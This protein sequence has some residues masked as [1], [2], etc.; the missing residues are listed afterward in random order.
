[1]RITHWGHL[2]K[3]RRNYDFEHPEHKRVRS[4]ILWRI[5]DLGYSLDCFEEIDAW[6]NQ[7]NQ[8]Y[9]RSKNGGKT[10]R[11]GKKYSWIAYFEL[12]GLRGD[13]KLL[14]DYF[15]DVRISD[16]DIDPS[17]PVEPQEHNLVTKNLLGTRK[18]PN[19]E[20]VSKNLVPDLIP[21]LK[22]NQLC[23]EEGDW[24]LLQGNLRQEDNQ[25]RREILAFVQGQ[26]VKAEEYEEIIEGLKQKKIDAHPARFCPEDY[27]T[28]AGE[29]P[30]CDTFPTNC[31]EEVSCEL[32]VETVRVEQSN[33]QAFKI[34]AP[35]RENSWESYHS[36]IIAGRNIA[37]PSRQIAET[38]G[39][40]EQPQSFN[41]FEK[42]GR[43]ASMTFR[44]GHNLTESQTFTYL[45]EDLLKRYLED[46]DGELIWVIWGEQCLVSQDQDTSIKPFEELREFEEVIAYRH[47]SNYL[48]NEHQ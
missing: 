12:A 45:R 9:G 10:D 37:T 4:N 31:W 42:D 32:G 1:M 2:V 3:D 17:F 33:Y 40:C 48:Q 38:F 18:M 13:K 5:Y 20:W 19:K 8:I 35:V 28:Y 15:D 6:I 24:I 27:Y 39:L 46:I 14:P 11:Y 7:G 25:A 21:Y 23:G 47:L 30:W 22:V 43:C 41:L 26:I 34:L 16:A 36:A 44:Y 29:I